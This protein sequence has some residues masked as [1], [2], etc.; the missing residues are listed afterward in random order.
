MPE[1]VT[2]K[3]ETACVAI[4]KS[5]AAQRVVKNTLQPA[6]YFAE[7]AGFTHNLAIDAAEKTRL[8]PMLHPK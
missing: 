6:D 5:D 3:L 1:A 4:M 8:V 2:H 7:A